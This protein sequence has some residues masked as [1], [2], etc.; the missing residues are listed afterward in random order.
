MDSKSKEILFEE[1]RKKSAN[2]FSEERTLNIE[3]NGRL[4]TSGEVMF[5]RYIKENPGKTS[6]QLA[7]ESG[8][9]RGTVSLIMKK[10]TEKN[11]AFFQDDPDH[12]KRKNIIITP[13]GEEICRMRDEYDIKSI[14]EFIN[15]LEKIYTPEQMMYIIPAMCELISFIK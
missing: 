10:L 12:R 4:Y 13:L 2:R 8:K 6:I 7:K 3:Y 1:W 11:L 9:T 15:N 14:Q 5:L